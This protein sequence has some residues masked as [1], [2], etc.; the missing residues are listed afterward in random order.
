LLIEVLA[1]LHL[2]K[3]FGLVLP[4]EVLQPPVQN[5]VTVFW[6]YG[7]FPE[8]LLRLGVWY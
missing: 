8:L 3:V 2:E 4:V 1:K 6:P 5:V 7:L